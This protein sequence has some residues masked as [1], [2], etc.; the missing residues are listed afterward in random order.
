[1]EATALIAEAV[2]VAAAMVMV[3]VVVAV[4]V[5]AVVTVVVIIVVAVAIAEVDVVMLGLLVG[6]PA[7]RRWGR[8][9]PLLAFALI[10]CQH[11]VISIFFVVRHHY[12]K[13]IGKKGMQS[14]A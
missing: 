11:L 13:E 8:L 4:V 9:L 5:A 14:H 6:W 2:V 1:M 10:L 12:C 3:A 7:R